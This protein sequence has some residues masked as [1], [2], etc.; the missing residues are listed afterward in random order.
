MTLDVSDMFRGADGFP[1]GLATA[2][3]AAAGNC[4]GQQIQAGHPAAGTVAPWLSTSTVPTV[5]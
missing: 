5:S 1:A 2:G 3:N 4:G